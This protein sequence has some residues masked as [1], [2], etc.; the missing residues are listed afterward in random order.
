[1]MSE[2]RCATLM[3]TEVEDG[4]IKA[5]RLIPHADSCFNK[6]CIENS[7][8]EKDPNTMVIPFEE[9]DE[10]NNVCNERILANKQVQE[11]LSA[12]KE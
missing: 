10:F 7:L 12:A 2:P 5:L 6:E 4:Q 9:L 11:F 3:V 1:M 8:K